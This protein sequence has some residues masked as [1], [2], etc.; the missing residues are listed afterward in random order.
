MQH[1]LRVA[2]MAA[3][4]LSLALITISSPSATTLGGLSLRI[5]DEVV[6]PGGTVQMKLELTEPQPISTGGGR[7]E[8]DAF[9]SIDGV[10]VSSS[11]D[12]T[13]AVAVVSGSGVGVAFNSPSA[14]FGLDNYPLLTITG[15][16]PATAPIGTRFP[17]VLDRTALRFFD[18]AGQLYG[19]ET[20][21]G[22][23]TVAN[24]LSI[25][26]VSPGSAE[27][28]A[29]SIVTVRGSG[30]DRRTKVELNGTVGESARFISP[31]QID[32]LLA[33]PVDMHGVRVR[34]RN[35]KADSGERIEYFS[36]QRTK[37]LGTPANTDLQSAVPLFP[38][39]SAA[40][41]AEFTVAGAVTALAVQN[42]KQDALVAA[43]LLSADGTV[44]ASAELAVP[45][46]HYVVRDDVELFGIVSP[47]GAIIRV[48]AQSPV[49][50]MG[51]AIDALG[52][53]T[54]IVPRPVPIPAPAI[55]VPPVIDA[56]QDIIG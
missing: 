41:S 21:N 34:A 2:A 49:Q 43:D 50:V 52:A 38:G 24:T 51:V 14:T 46:N 10:A 16:V 28:P 37:P 17:F 6:P 32:L 29:G 45:T 39:R 33:A 7:F 5:E 42:L 26:D 11:S 44:L 3:A 19:A 25:E 20:K 18:P 22:T 48:R 55:D 54:P 31:T 8:F 23:L 30:F 1:P 36:Y 35:P 56:P 27:L 9:Q 4:S 40:E 47:P 15:R 13:Y 53:L 12:D